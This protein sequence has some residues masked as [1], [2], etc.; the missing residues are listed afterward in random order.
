MKVNKSSLPKLNQILHP[1][2]LKNDKNKKKKPTVNMG[3]MVEG[4]SKV[5]E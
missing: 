4:R 1:I 3:L 2:G 5:I